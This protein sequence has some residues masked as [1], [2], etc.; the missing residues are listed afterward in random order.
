MS[1]IKLFLAASVCAFCYSVVGLAQSTADQLDYKPAPYMFVGLQGGAQTTFTDF[2]LSKLITPTASVSFGAFFT[3][4]IGAR[5]H[6]NGIWDKGGIKTNGESNFTYDYKYLTSD[7]DLLVNLS[8]LIGKNDYY[9]WNVYLIGGTGLTYAWDNGD[10]RK[11]AMSTPTTWKKNYL[12]HNLRVGAMVDYNLNKHWSVNLEVSANNLSDRFN[13][14]LSHADDWKLTAQLGVAYKFGFSKK[15]H[16]APVVVAP[17]EEFVGDKNAETTAAKLDVPKAEKKAEPA[18]VAAVT[19]IQDDVFFDIRS[20]EIRPSEK[21]KID[22]I[23]KWLKDNPKAEA[24][25]TGHADAG[26]GN[27]SLNA[28][29]AKDRAEAVAKYMKSAGIEASRLKVDSKGDK[30]MPY[31][32]NE[33]SRVAI[34]VGSG[35]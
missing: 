22:K 8:T 29:Y 25:V 7:I 1:R 24:T 32:D 6:V 10:L 28:K 20:S 18:P 2:K 12:S 34:I 17:V 31:G 3:P 26:T 16:T 35:K 21:A 33:K 14:K 19:T 23:I 15:V 11:S 4:V 9:P 13:C 30:V 27:T 5:L